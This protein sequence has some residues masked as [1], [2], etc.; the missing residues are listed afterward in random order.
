MF[1][2]A[3]WG[4]GPLT[5]TVAS[6]GGRERNDQEKNADGVSG[7]VPPVGSCRS[8]GFFR[9][10]E[11][12][13]LTARKTGSF[14]ST[15][16][17]SPGRLGGGAR[18]PT[19][20]R[21]QSRVA[22]PPQR[23]TTGPLRRRSARL[24]P[25]FDRIVLPGALLMSLPARLFASVAL[26]LG[27]TLSTML[28]LSAEVT[29]EPFGKTAD[30]QAVEQYTLKNAEG[31]TAQIITRGATLR[32]MHVVDQSGTRADVLLGFDSVAGYESDANQYFGPIV[33]RVCNR[34]ADAQFELAGERYQ[35]TAND[36]D[37][38]LHGGGE[39]SLDKVVWEAEVIE[40]AEYPSVRFR[41][42][43]PDGQEGFPGNLHVRVRYTL[44]DKNAVVIA[45]EATTDIT[46]PVNLTNHAYFNLAGAGDETIL[47][48][49]LMIE[50][51]YYTPTDD[52]L[53]PTGKIAAVEGS[54]LDFRTPTAIG[55]RLA[56]VA[57]TAALG[58]D[59]NYVL[60]NQGTGIRRVAR[61]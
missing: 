14:P 13:F 3:A 18:W 61:V 6:I 17:L 32:S 19:R 55:K 56:A 1:K 24:R 35:L 39:H 42:F 46:T 47:D 10:D 4:P 28:P 58:Y 59:H 20:Q 45:Y 8:R 30:G 9:A 41:Y 38:T 23:L 36:G 27:G 25:P 16:L 52:E 22:R 49:Q 40:D 48:H 15:T 29:V 21:L 57:D 7:G 26:G 5:A 44:T 43:S 33:G 2:Q 12:A 53:I 31:T 60:N 50:A 54:P 51:D 34:I 37:N 11:N